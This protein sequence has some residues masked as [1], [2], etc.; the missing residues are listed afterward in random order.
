M[1]LKQE[2]QKLLDRWGSLSENLK[3]KRNETC[4]M[5][6]VE[7]DYVTKKYQCLELPAISNINLIWLK[8]EKQNPHTSDKVPYGTRHLTKPDNTNYTKNA[9]K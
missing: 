5:D 8:N 3:M 7:R 6:T 1:H 4:T 2:S 9:F